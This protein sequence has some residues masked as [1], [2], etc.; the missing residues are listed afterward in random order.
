M[1]SRVRLGNFVKKIPIFMQRKNLAV[2]Y[3]GLTLTRVRLFT[4]SNL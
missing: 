1:L 3:I 4:A 2:R